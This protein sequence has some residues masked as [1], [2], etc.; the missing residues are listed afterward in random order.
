MR[1]FALLFLSA[2]FFLL[3][4]NTAFSQSAQ[5]APQGTSHDFSVVGPANWTYQWRLVLP[6]GNETVLAATGNHS[7]EISFDEL[8]TYTLR[9]QATDDNGCLSEWVSATIEVET[10]EPLQA[11]ADAA[12][13]NMDEPVTIAVLANDRGLTARTVQETP[14]QT[15]QGGSLTQQADGSITYTPPTGFYG[16]DSFT[17]QLQEDANKSTG[18]QAQVFITVINTALAQATPLAVADVNAGW[19]NQTVQGNVLTNDLFYDPA[20]VQLGVVTIPEEASGKLTS[21]NQTTGEYTFVPA[22]DYSGEAVF[23]YKICQP[24]P[25]GVERCTEAEAVIQILQP[26]YTNQAP[27]A[28]DDVAV[29]RVGQPVSGNFLHND[30]DPEGDAIRIGMVN[31]NGLSGTFTWNANGSYTYTPAPGFSGQQHVTYRVC[32]DTGNCDWGTLNLYVLEPALFSAG[33]YANDDVF[34]GEGLVAG[35]L[36]LNE[37]NQTGGNLVYQ[38]TPVSGPAHGEVTI[39]P[40]GRF[41]YLPHAG[42]TGQLADRFVY[43][44]CSASD[45]SAC[46]EATA[47]L[48]SD[49]PEVFIVVKNQVGTGSCVPVT[50]DASASTGAGEIS[51]LWEPADYL[52]DANSATPQFMPGASTQ[53]RLTVTDQLGHSAS[54]TVQVNVDAAPEIVTNNQLFVSSPGSSILLDASESTGADLQFSWWSEQGGVIV[55]GANTA[56]PEVMGIGKYYLRITDTYGCTDLDSVM[57]GLYVQVEAV[58]DTAEVIMNASVAISV[59]ENDRPNGELNPASITIVSLPENGRVDLGADA[60]ITYTPNEYYLGQDQFVYAICN[61]LQECD[62]AT[63]LVMVNEEALFIPN[64]FSPNGDGY[65]DYFEIKGIY[66]YSNAHLKV[67]NRW[68]NL[69]YEMDKYGVGAGRSGFWD[70]I[71]NKGVRIGTGEIPTGTYFYILDL[72]VNGKKLTGYVYIDR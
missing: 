39:Q 36:S 3:G 7:G 29:T 67:F 38:S 18:S 31:D 53:Y 35:N 49:I 58:N 27:V 45:P 56:T 28:N 22:N 63:V 12:T 13:T 34:Y 37:I 6:S 15:T 19:P 10:S 47:Y 50:L 42:S 41:E 26:A 48:V 65:N 52:S 2:L 30:L 57:V 59:L 71:V 14:A 17:Y 24:D 72:G 23:K 9:V 69:V 33:L 20:L 44:V 66:N 1:H 4:E 68:G 46:S 70:G 16:N 54:R 5:T 62:E 21:F 61:Y 55:A 32:D 43:R 64:A 60:I 8:G 11:V 25:N 40:D 51:F